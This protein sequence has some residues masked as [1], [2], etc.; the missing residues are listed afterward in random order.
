[1]DTVNP[2]ELLSYLQT[3]VCQSIVIEDRI[4]RETC[5]VVSAD[6]VREVIAMLVHQFQIYHLTTITAQQ[7][8]QKWIEIGYHFWRNGGLTITTILE[9][10]SPQILSIIDMIPG[11]DFYER[12]VAEMYGVHFPNRQVTHPLLLPDD[13]DDVPPMLLSEEKDE[14]D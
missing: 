9:S 4:E 7:R 10:S 14:Q 8:E 11:A 6:K 2:L 3:K 5:F 12:E 1:L 13:W